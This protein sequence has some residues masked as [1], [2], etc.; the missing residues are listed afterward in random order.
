MHTI[1]ILAAGNSSRIKNPKSKIFLKINGESLIDST[2]NL[3][4]KTHPAEIFI[5]IKKKDLKFFKSKKYKNIKFLFQKKPLGTGDAFKT[6]VKSYKGN[7]E[8]F[9]ILNGDTPFINLRD[10][11]KM[12]KFIKKNSIIL[13]GFKT[14]KNQDLGL[15]K[16][17]K[18]KQVL[19][20]I[21]YKNANKDDKKI[22]ICNSGVILMNKK[23]ANYVKKIV[24]DKITKEYYLTE[25]FEIL[26]KR[27]IFSELITTKNVLGSKGI[28]TINDYRLN[29]F[30]LTK[31][32]ERNI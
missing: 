29:K 8:N 22:N 23:I 12:L 3:A 11:N 9:L 20:I 16:V 19:K 14:N 10:I 5:I 7:S 26:K 28:N 24:K 27:K 31:K 21:E 15:I 13:L 2:I 4:K 6:F 18:K 17:N 25:I 1:I 30:F 32:N